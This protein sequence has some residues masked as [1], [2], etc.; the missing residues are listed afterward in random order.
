MHTNYISIYA[1]FLSVFLIQ[2]SANAAPKSLEEIKAEI[3]QLATKKEA[4][5]RREASEKLAFE[6]DKMK[7]LGL[8]ACFDGIAKAEGFK[9][10]PSPEEFWEQHNI[11][12][13]AMRTVWM[14]KDDEKELA[15]NNSEYCH[16]YA[17][18][19]NEPNYPQNTYDRRALPSFSSRSRDLT[20][21]SAKNN[22]GYE[23]TIRIHR[24]LI[25]L[26]LQQ[27]SW[28]LCRETILIYINRDMSWHIMSAIRTLAAFEKATSDNALAVL[29][30]LFAN[31]FSDLEKNGEF[32]LP[33]E[34]LI[35]PLEATVEKI[36]LYIDAHTSKTDE[37]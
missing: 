25:S 34:R 3:A 37:L 2:G 26:L 4:S 9:S 29:D 11:A 30:S 7:G 33:H 27:E 8:K 21:L 16:F 5:K 31:E 36:Q 18:F 13:H 28:S 35:K 6:I 20:D 1:A 14:F 32:V 19:T 12:N 23:R 22:I 15:K 10:D 24:H 17:Y